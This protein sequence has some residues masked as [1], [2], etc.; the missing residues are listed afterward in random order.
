VP[1]LKQSCFVKKGGKSFL[2]LECPE[3]GTELELEGYR[4]LF[5]TCP[6]CGETFHIK[7]CIKK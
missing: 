7:D 2:K 4:I 3:C 6:E 1:E 5:P